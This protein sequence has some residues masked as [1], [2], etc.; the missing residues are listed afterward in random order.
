MTNAQWF[1]IMKFQNDNSM[2]CMI[3]D[4]FSPAQRLVKGRLRQTTDSS[5]H[6]KSYSSCGLAPV[7]MATGY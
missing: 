3:P 2:Y 7:T 5:S 6:K 1:A 4:P